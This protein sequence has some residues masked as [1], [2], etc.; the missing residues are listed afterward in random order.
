MATLYIIIAIVVLI[1]GIGVYFLIPKKGKWSDWKKVGGCTKECNQEY[2]RECSNS[3]CD[4]DSKKTDP[5]SLEECG[6][7]SEWKSASLCSKPCGPGTKEFSRT[8]LK[9]NCQGDTK[10]VD[11]CKIKECPVHGQWSAWNQQNVC[12]CEKKGVTDIVFKRACSNPPP[13][14]GGRNCFGDSLF[15]IPC[16]KCD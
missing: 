11:A 4:G 3:N 1:I 12:D 6:V 2:T 13:Q 5:C 10:K 8:C 16:P 14:Y 9:G 7:W 15:K